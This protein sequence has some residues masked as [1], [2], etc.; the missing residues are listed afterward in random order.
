MRCLARHLSLMVFRTE[1]QVLVLIG[2]AKMWAVHSSCMKMDTSFNTYIYIYVN[3]KEFSNRQLS[4]SMLVLQSKLTVI[5][6]GRRN[7][8]TGL[9]GSD[10]QSL[11]V[12]LPQQENI[13]KLLSNSPC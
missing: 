2:T 5:T 11:T 1:D 8:F 9:T 3:K 7:A 13:P 12:E 4:T 6:S 10:I